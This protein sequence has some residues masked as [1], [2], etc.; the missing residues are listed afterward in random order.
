VPVVSPPQPVTMS[1]VENA[2]TVLLEASLRVMRRRKSSSCLPPTPKPRTLHHH[3]QGDPRRGER[4]GGVHR[5][6]MRR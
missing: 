6:R 5:P 3:G 2:A 4:R 1:I